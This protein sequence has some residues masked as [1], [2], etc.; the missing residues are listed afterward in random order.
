MHSTTKYLGGHSDV[1]GGALVARENDDFFRRVRAVQTGGGLVPSPFDSWLVLRGIRTLP[2]RMRAHS[3][4][5][6]RAPVPLGHRNVVA[7]HSPGS[8]PIPVTGG[9]AA[10]V[11]AGG[12][13]PSRCAAVAR[14]HGADRATPRLHP[15]DQ[16]RRHG[17]PHRAP[18]VRGGRGTRAPEDSCG[19]RSAS[20][21]RTTCWRIWRGARLLRG[22]GARSEG[23][24]RSTPH[25]PLPL[26]SVIDHAPPLVP[27]RLLSGARLHHRARYA[28]DVD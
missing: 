16:S 25:P 3:A 17:E 13:S 11:A 24:V 5:A 22:V 6:E 20:R 8:S 28:L 15:R 2:W 26:S 9:E 1:I 14:P 19:Y 21:T 4:N 12:C 10:D 27:R 23:R 7:V 18:G